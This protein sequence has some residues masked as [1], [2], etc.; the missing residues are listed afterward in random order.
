VRQLAWLALLL[1]L[2][3]GERSSAVEE[4]SQFPGLPP[5]SSDMCPVALRTE[6]E[7]A[8]A[9]VTAKEDNASANGRLG[10]VLH[11]CD[12]SG[13]AEVCYRRA[14]LLDHDS[15]RWAYLLGV[16]NAHQGKFDRAAAAFSQAQ[17][18]NAEYLPA[19]LNLGECLLATGK[20]Q[21]AGKLYES[22]VRK[23][24]ELAQ[25]YYGLGRVRAVR[26][27]LI[28]AVESL[29][30]ACEL[31]PD[32]GAAHYALAH[33]YKRLGRSDEAVEEA[34]LYEGRKSASPEIEDHLM[35]EIRN[36]PVNPLD[37]LR[38]GNSLAGEG[39]LPQ[40]AAAFEKALNRDPNLTPAHIKLISVYGQLG[41]LQNAESHFRAAVRLSPHDPEIFFNYGQAL[42]T[43]ERFAEAEE[44]F[45]HVLKISPRYSDAQLNLGSMLEAEGKLSDA[46]TAY[47]QAFK[48]N[49]KDARPSFGIGRILVNQEKYEE[50]IQ[51]LQRSLST[52]DKESEPAYL[53]A[54]GAAYTRAGD[55][56]NGLRYL[57]QARK[58]ATAQGQSK[59]VES[60][61]ADLR[62]V[63]MDGA[64]Q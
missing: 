20:W 19:Q 29:R 28:G 39:R 22:I 31:V 55:R 12:H 23:H 25:G 52:A 49:P 38:L 8:Y 33:S 13:E 48:S 60:I 54:L 30:R 62:A 50:G 4:E 17:V 24:P 58:R 35:D 3:T 51:Y 9:A 34:S 14:H 32:F 45:R 40:A 18:L 16:V 6:L 26:G 15:F 1:A 57:E 63:R 27:D 21:E 11:A 36:F 64:S 59:L 41:Q 2:A 5:I 61:D 42:A 44:A 46:I 53:Y 7:K 10:M 37:Q 43:E 56:E 47:E